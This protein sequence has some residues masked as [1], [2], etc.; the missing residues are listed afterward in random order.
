MLLAQN[1]CILVAVRG[2]DAPA[3][4][5][6]S[7]AK[8]QKILG[9]WEHLQIT[10]A[11]ALEEIH[12]DVNFWTGISFPFSPLISVTWQPHRSLRWCITGVGALR[13]CVSCG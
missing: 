5:E 12:R 13:W 9:K 1:A 8:L 10:F 7:E 3:F 11:D 2:M 4:P 6:F